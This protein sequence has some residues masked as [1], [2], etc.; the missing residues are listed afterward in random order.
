MK[1]FEQLKKVREKRGT[2]A[3]ALI[4]PDV[5]NDHNLSETVKLITDSDYD[6]IFVGGS[7]IMDNLFEDRMGIIRNNSDLPIIIFPGSSNQLSSKADAVLF[8]S[9][10]SGRNPQ[11]LIG[12]H[13]QSAPKIYNLKIE[14]IPTGYILVDGNVP[15]SVAVM[16]NTNPLPMSKPEII[17]AHA[18][19]GEYLGMKQIFIEAGSGAKNH[20]SKNLIELLS[21]KLSI[22]LVVGGG[23]RTPESAMKLAKA[24][25]G[26]IVTG[27]IIEEDGSPRL[28][29]SLTKSIH[30]L[31]N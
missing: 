14:P 17:L 26:C 21:S 7:L 20:A 19:A 2:C 15:S 9:L 25:A 11:Y 6:A 4:D 29:K 16:S 27:N 3:I 22:P 18:L 23:I 5:K 12:E 31:E 13:V 28:L 24:G 30:Y 10:L 1:I 8:L